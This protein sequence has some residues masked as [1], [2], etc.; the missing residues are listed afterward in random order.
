MVEFLITSLLLSISLSTLSYGQVLKFDDCTE[1][2]YYAGL[3]EDGSNWTR[4]ELQSL[5]YRTHRSQVEFTNNVDPGFEDVWGALMDVDEAAEPGTVSLIYSADDEFLPFIPFGERTWVRVHLF[6]VLRGVGLDGPD[7]TD[8]H[9]IRPATT[10]S[11]IVVDDKYFGVCEVLTPPDTCVAPAEGAGPDTCACQRIFEP[12]ASK[13]GDIARALMYMDLRYD[14]NEPNTLDLRLTDCPFQAERDMAYLSQMLTWHQE[15]PPDDAERIRN[16]K[17]CAN[18]QGNRNPFID[19][20]ELA[21]V[22]FPPPSP[23]PEVGQEQLIYDKCQA[24]PTLP[25]TADANECDLVPEGDIVPFLV[26]SGGTS[27]DDKKSELLSLGLYSFGP[28]TAGFELFLTDY[29][30]NGETFVEQANITTDG[31]IKVRKVEE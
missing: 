21:D 15:D 1:A 13:K 4:E 16:F 20:P 27:E 22:L 2:I 19:F 8:I 10:L 3:P 30:W 26:N 6:P 9:A 12:P 17:T 25:P 31:T 28:M 29:P 7:A 14:G 5:I 11:S 23:L 24:I 18:W